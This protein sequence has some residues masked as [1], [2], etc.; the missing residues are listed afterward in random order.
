MWPAQLG[1]VWRVMWELNCDPLRQCCDGVITQH[2]PCKRHFALSYS[3]CRGRPHLGFSDPSLGRLPALRDNTLELFRKRQV[4][5]GSRQFDFLSGAGGK[6]GRFLPHRG[7][8]QAFKCITC[9]DTSDYDSLVHSTAP[10]LSPR[11]H[12]IANGTSRRDDRWY[13]LIWAFLV[14]VDNT[15]HVSRTTDSGV[16]RSASRGDSGTYKSAFRA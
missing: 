4:L 10:S 16:L 1:W 2:H 13:S 15:V 9:P 3:I 5:A 11:M 14:A 8:H 6:P 12:A 7:I